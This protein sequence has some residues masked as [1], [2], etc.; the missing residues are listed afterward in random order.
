[1]K[2]MRWYDL[3]SVNIFWLGLNIRNTAVGSYFMPYLVDQFVGPEI[4]NTALGGMRTAGLVIAMLVQPAFGLISDRSTSHW[5]R[6]RPYILVGVLLDLLFLACIAWSFD[7]WSF[8]VATLLIQFSANISHGPLQGLIP[9]LVP[10]E[11]RSIAS[12]VKAVFELLPII[13]L[14]FTVAKIIGAGQFDLAVLVTAVAL[15][16]LMLLTMVLVKETPLKEKPAVPL[17]PTMFRVLGMLAGI[18]VGALAGLAAGGL[19]GGLI[20]LIVWPLAG[21]KAALSV[22]VAVGSIIAMAVAVVVG[23]WAGTLTTIGKEIRRQPSFTWWVVNRLMFL[24]AITSIQGVVMYFLMHTFSI[25]RDAATDMTGTLMTVVGVFTLVSALASGWLASRFGDKRMVTW[26]GY[27]AATGTVILLATFWVPSLALI[28]AAGCILGLAAGLFM[29]TNWSLGTRLAPPDEAGRYLGISNLAG[30]G[31][32][33]IGQGIGG[34]IADYLNAS[35]PGLGYLV[36]FV[37]YAVLFVLSSLTLRW[38]ADPSAVPAG[39]AA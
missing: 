1:M 3:I 27:I 12:A 28:Y 15:L 26:S 21:S 18:A 37:G 10:E 19:V 35:L 17:G 11:R 2:R 16:V 5:G 4:R 7:Y 13:L 33:M 9:D 20:G 23:T 30:A 36:I 34:P 22:G 39:Q 38:V 29:T 25:G 14:G 31:A 32:G 24:A 6:R 8:L